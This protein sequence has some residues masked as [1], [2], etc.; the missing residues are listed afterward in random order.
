MVSTVTGDDM[1]VSK[2]R[3]TDLILDLR[4]KFNGTYYRNVIVTQLKLY[5]LSYV[6]SMVSF[7]SSSKTKHPHAWHRCGR[8]IVSLSYVYDTYERETIS[9][10]DWETSAAIL[11]NSPHLKSMCVNSTEPSALE[12][13]LNEHCQELL[14]SYWRKTQPHIHCMAGFPITSAIHLVWDTEHRVGTIVRYNNTWLC[15]TEH[16]SLICNT[17]KI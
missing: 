8:C 11:S 12:A 15:K 9:L 1:G 14:T 17:Y 16:L 5:R 6:R 2:I 4:V 7:L 10:V 3:S 13:M